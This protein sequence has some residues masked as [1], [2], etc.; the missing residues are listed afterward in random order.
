MIMQFQVIAEL[1]QDLMDAQQCVVQ[2]KMSE[3]MRK[4]HITALEK[5]CFCHLQTSNDFGATGLFFSELKEMKHCFSKLEFHN[6]KD[7]T[8]E[9]AV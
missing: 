1:R 9:I 2:D 8:L 4:L 6:L 7:G 3:I 5:D